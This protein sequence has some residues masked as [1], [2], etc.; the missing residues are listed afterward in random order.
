MGRISSTATS[1]TN[2]ASALAPSTERRLNWAIDPGNPANN[3]LIANS[4]GLHT[5]ETVN[6]I[7]KGANYGYSQREGNELLKP[8]N[9][10]LAESKP[11]GPDEGTLDATITEDGQFI[12][13]YDASV[14]AKE[15]AVL[16]EVQRGRGRQTAVMKVTY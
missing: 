14:K 9:T 4:V 3:R 8:D 7:R 10:K 1:T 11:V 12:K 5:W 2:T 6:I 15:K 16:L 13:L